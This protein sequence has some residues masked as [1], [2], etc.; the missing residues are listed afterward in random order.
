MSINST[1]KLVMILPTLKKEKKMKTTDYEIN[2]V[3]A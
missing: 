3:R 1:M 2:E